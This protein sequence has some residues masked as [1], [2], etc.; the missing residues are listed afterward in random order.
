MLTI[1]IHTTQFS[2]R[3]DQISASDIESLGGGTEVKNA[4]D[5]EL[6]GLRFL[7]LGGRSVFELQFSV[8]RVDDLSLTIYDREG[9]M[10][11]YEM[12]GDFNGEYENVIDLNDRP[13]GNYYL[14]LSQ[15]GKTF[16]RKVIKG[17]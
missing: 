4:D 17:E 14:Q 2:L 1:L 11:Y 9:K 10:V 13:S 16:S 7:P 6:Q 5:L 8:E 12:L 3:F 15:G